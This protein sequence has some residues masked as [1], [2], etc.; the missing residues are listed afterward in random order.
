MTISILKFKER[1]YLL[2]YPSPGSWKH[3]SYPSTYTHSKLVNQ[4]SQSAL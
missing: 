4:F 1:E 2:V 3:N